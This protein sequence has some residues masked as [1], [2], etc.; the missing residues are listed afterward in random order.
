MK[1][2]NPFS[3]IEVMI[4]IAICAAV[5]SA[6]GW[7]MHGMIVKKRFSSSVERLCSRLLTCRRLA[8][9]MQADWGVSLYCKGN[10][11]FLKAECID[12]PEVKALPPLSLGFLEFFLDDKA[13]ERISFAFTAT[14]DILP[15]G[16]LK[17]RSK[18]AGAVEI[19][20][21]NLFSVQGGKALG[22]MH[23]DDW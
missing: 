23:P 5:A 16:R 15:E 12:S 19:D 7:K 1:T 6:I 20:L 22:P 13:Q 11:T 21:L 2:K 17:I 3:L 4:A 18:K 8:M 10:Q 14:G 9:N